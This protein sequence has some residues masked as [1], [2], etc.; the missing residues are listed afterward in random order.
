MREI[1]V[2]LRTPTALGRLYPRYDTEANLL[3]VGSA[4]P[5]DWP[6]GVD[7]DG[8][9]IFDIDDDRILAN[10]DLLI[11]KELWKVNPLPNRPEPLREADI[12]FLD[13]TIRH[14]SFNMPLKVQTD[15]NGSYVYIIFG[16]SKNSGVW[17]ALSEYCMA[18][19]SD[20]C[21]SGFFVIL[22]NKY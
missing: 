17:I 12:E 10:F 3:E 14:K 8:A 20:S 6:Y 4:I 18:L 21:L 9:L 13:E 11:R 2:R 7:I 1:R 5:R 15:R 19:I 22:S 16:K